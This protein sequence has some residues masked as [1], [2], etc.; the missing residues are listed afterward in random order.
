MKILHVN[1]NDIDGGAARSAYRLHEELCE[2]GIDSYFFTQEKHKTDRRVFSPKGKV[3]YLKTFFNKNFEIAIKLFFNISINV[4]WSIN[5]GFS[6]YLI[7]EINQADIVNLHW[8]NGGFL[9]ID[10]LR[11]INKPIVWTLHDSWAFTGGCHIPYNCNNY[12]MKCEKCPQ[13]NKNIY[14][15]LSKR[16]FEIKEKIYEKT[17]MQVIVPSKWMKECAEK[18]TLLKNKNIDLIP[19]GVDVLKYK[20]LDRKSCRDILGISRNKKIVLFGAMNSNC[21]VNKGFSYLKEALS[22]LKDYIDIKNVELLVFGNEKEERKKNSAFPVT[23]IGR[24]YDDISLNILYSSAD[25]MVVPSKSENLPN[26]VME[27][28]A[29]GT[30]CVGFAIGGIPDM[31]KHKV[32]GYLAHPYKVDDLARGIAYILKYPNRWTVL[33]QNARK[34]I[35]SDFNLNLIADKYIEIYERNIFFNSLG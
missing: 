15:D 20:V 4:P 9:P 27:A 21:D 5:K 2:K 33:S 13:I 35:S 3:G 7:S 6:Q 31:I 11:K 8:I 22:L 14:F 1:T 19:N 17:R 23:Y 25:L 30:P 10:I 32:N 18:S 16:N 26:T 24:L 12:H 29:S 34:I 28:M